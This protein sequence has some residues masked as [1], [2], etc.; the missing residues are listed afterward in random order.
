M[1]LTEAFLI[2]LVALF[3][4]FVGVLGVALDILG[5]RVTS[6]TLRRI[7]PPGDLM[8]RRPR[9]LYAA[10]WAVFLVILGEFIAVALLVDGIRFSNEAQVAAAL[11]EF[12]AAAVVVVVIARGT[13]RM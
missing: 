1:S 11:V 4:F 12:I 3:A 13:R 7:L 6:P 9:S 8:P 2:A 10:A 5:R